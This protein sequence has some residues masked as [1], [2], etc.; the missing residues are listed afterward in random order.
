VDDS[1][2]RF[3][4]PRVVHSAN[5][6][7]ENFRWLRLRQLFEHLL[8][9]AIHHSESGS[10]IRISCARLDAQLEIKIADTGSGLTRDQID[11]LF[12]RRSG[13]IPFESAGLGA[14]VTLAHAIVER[15]RG[16]LSA[17]SQGPGKGLTVLVTLPA[18]VRD[19]QKKRADRTQPA[20]GGSAVGVAMSVPK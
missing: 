2:S 10:E 4:P 5:A 15:H 18:R 8:R 6:L 7:A 9:N 14:G 13:D 12:Q 19:E 3:R 11:S 20:N 17:E 1:G 16:A